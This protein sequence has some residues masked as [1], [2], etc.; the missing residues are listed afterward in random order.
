MATTTDT[1]IKKLPQEVTDYH[2]SKKTMPYRCHR[3]KLCNASIVKRD[4]HCFF[5]NTC[6]GYYNQKYFMWY[7][8]QMFCGTAYSV[9]TNA[10]YTS[11]VY[12]TKFTG[13]TTFIFLGPYTILNWWY[14]NTTSGEM[15]LVV[16]MYL[17][18]T[19]GIVCL[20]FFLWQLWISTVGLTTFE[21]MN[22]VRGFDNGLWSNLS[23]V[24]GKFWMLGALFPIPLPQC[25]NGIYGNKYG[26]VDDD[27]D[28]DGDLTKA[29]EGNGGSCSCGEKHKNATDTSKKNK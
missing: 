11:R 20:G 12:G 4:H 25:G 18:L 6:I 24:L 23:D 15:F 9:I 1:S 3:C 26:E 8:I 16:F 19:A 21:A 2:K 10:M 28:D 7:C 27:D 5:M 13:G 22:D 17:S 14:K 29:R